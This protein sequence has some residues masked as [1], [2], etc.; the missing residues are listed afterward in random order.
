MTMPIHDDESL[1]KGT[2]VAERYV[3]EGELGRGN[4]ATVYAARD[5]RDGKDVALK[6]MAARLVGRRNR[7][8]RFFNES[9]MQ[10]AVGPHVNIV[11]ALGSGRV[12]D[13]GSAPFMVMERVFGGDLSMTLALEGR[14]STSRAV[15]IF[16]GV[17]RGLEAMHSAGVIHRDTTP[18]N[19]MLAV[20]EDRRDSGEIAK[21]TDFGLAAQLVDADGA[22]VPR[23]TRHY[24][25]PG[26][27]GYIAPEL[28]AQAAPDPS[29]DV[30][31][32]GM[33][34]LTA[35]LGDNPYKR[36][37][38]EDYLAEVTRDGWE[39]PALVLGKIESEGLRALVADCTRQVAAERPTMHR[40]IDCL[41]ALGGR[42]AADSTPSVSSEVSVAPTGRRR[43]I[44]G[45]MVAA[46]FVMLIGATVVLMLWARPGSPDAPLEVPASVAGPA[47]ER[48]EDGAEVPSSAGTAAMSSTD[49]STG[50]V[51]GGGDTTSGPGASE[52]SEGME[53]ESEP[54]PPLVEQRRT[55]R[56]KRSKTKTPTPSEVPPTIPPAE[57]QPS[58]DD[59]ECSSVRA[60]IADAR[61]FGRW[62]RVPFAIKA[63]RACFPGTEYHRLLV[64]ALARSGRTTECQEV[65]ERSSDPTVQEWV[66]K[67]R[68][69]Q[70]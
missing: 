68:E 31:G 22:P 66:A 61:K 10:A 8:R 23:M 14:L 58:T 2:T 32:F 15:P 54:D 34:L 64:E 20:L 52:A 44:A 62:G 60:A 49:G 28:M 46:L 42:S 48:G 63:Q 38:R 70:R 65:G 4:M 30:F 39:L 3:I 1:E 41:E 57:A 45:P 5:L 12:G 35:L 33:L 47:G 17:A 43:T 53:A 56:S 25:V 26:T 69:D 36:L 21:L 59:G 9:R 29:A 37:P 16:L 11:Q 50:E 40:V 27:V 13:R 7:E 18:G 51:P 24:A 6:V 55:D 67:C 19:V